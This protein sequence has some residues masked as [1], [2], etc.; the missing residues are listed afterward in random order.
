MVH[1]LDFFLLQSSEKLIE[2]GEEPCAVQ[3]GDKEDFMQYQLEL[4]RA[5]GS[6]GKDDLNQ[7]FIYKIHLSGNF[8]MELTEEFSLFMSTLVQGGM[9]KTA[10]DLSNLKYIDSTGIG[11]IINMTKMMRSRGGELCF[12]N[13]NPKIM[14]IFNLVKLNDYI[15]FFKSDKQVAEHLFTLAR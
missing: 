5:P 1:I 13:V 3:A 7:V 10:F 9:R 4:L 6:V 11:V 2:L 8:V 12:V 14:E 15:Q